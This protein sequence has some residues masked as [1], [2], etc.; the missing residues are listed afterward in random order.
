VDPF[1]SGLEMAAAI[2]SGELDPVEVVDTCLSRID[3]L[4]PRLNSVIWRCDDEARAAARH[5]REAVAHGE[6]LGPLHGV[7]IPIK[8]LTDVEGWTTTFGSRGAMGRVAPAT[9]HVAQALRDAGAILL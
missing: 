8:D 2:R 9:A 1:L 4:N 3:L 6:R 5:A 7:P